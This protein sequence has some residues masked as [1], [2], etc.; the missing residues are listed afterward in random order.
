MEM[1]L[2]SPVSYLL[3]HKLLIYHQR[4]SE[5]AESHIESSSCA[6]VFQGKPVSEV[7]AIAYVVV[8]VVVDVVVVVAI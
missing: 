3:I 2:F 4:R 6:E 1:T 5:E 8:V 7:S